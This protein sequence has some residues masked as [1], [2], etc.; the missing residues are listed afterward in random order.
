MELIDCHSHSSLSGHGEGSI[1]DAVNRAKELGLSVYAQTEHLVLPRHLDF[2]YNVSMA[3][4]VMKDYIAELKRQRELLHESG[5][6]MILVI[7]TEADWLNNREEELIDLCKDF[8]YVIGS[9][10]MLDEWP[11]DSKNDREKYLELGAD[12]VWKRYFEVWLDMANSKAPINT[13]GHPDLPKKFGDFP[14]FDT[15]EYYAEMASAAARTGRMVE[16]NTAGLRYPVEEL[17]P[18]YDLLKA[19]CDAGVPCTVGCDAHR[20]QDIGKNVKDAY[21]AMYKAGYRYVAAPLPDGDRKMIA[22]EP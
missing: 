17:Y 4:H 14:S 11:F 2:H 1:A 12:Y 22:L 5:S 10:H 3:P 7:G 8:E 13:F 16:V 15:R 19:F 18:G 21:E 6:K 20:P 9:V